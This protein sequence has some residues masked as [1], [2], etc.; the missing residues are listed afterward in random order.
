MI[1]MCRLTS[2]W[3]LLVAGI[4]GGCSSTSLLYS[5][6]PWLV[7]DKIDDYF[8]VSSN[9]EQQLDQDIGLFFKWHRYQELPKYVKL[10]SAFNRQIADGLTREELNLLFDQL[11]AA[12][13]RFAEASLPSA[14]L[15]LASI[16]NKQIERF[17]S[18]FRQKLVEDR[19]HFELTVKQQKEENF[20]KLLDTLEDWFGDF[21]Q[22][23][24]N[25][26]RVVSNARPMNYADWLNRREQR[27]REFLQFLRSKPNA[28]SIKDYLRRQYV[29]G[30]KQNSNGMLKNS[31]QFWLS[32]LLDIDQ[33]ISPVQRQ[34]AMARLDNYRKD[35][36]N[37][38]RQKPRVHRVVI[39]R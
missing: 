4:L 30:F 24:Q 27:H 5:N 34:Q 3:V 22:K 15:F 36:E 14:S 29:Q 8:S 19:E 33:M 31:R 25:A 20:S 10:I 1:T 6:A 38:S 7:L 13:V 18:E 23:Q 21:D 2:F 28:P 35:F 32:A 11:A 39:E 16:D 9:Q 12:R 37:L 26:L 17:D